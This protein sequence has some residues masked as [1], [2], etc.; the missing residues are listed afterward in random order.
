MS[1]VS[2]G[3]LTKS[4]IPRHRH[5]HPRRLARHAYTSLRPIR[6]I[7]SRG[8]R[9]VGRVGVDVGVGVLES[10]LND[11]HSTVGECDRQLTRLQQHS[12]VIYANATDYSAFYTG[13][14]QRTL[15]DVDTLDF[16]HA[17]APAAVH[18]FQGSE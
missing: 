18:P 6:T 8:C 17:R 7:S 12:G 10:G 4:R 1:D 9:R 14:S 2:Q 15:H 5:R 11:T 13:N 3:L 16:V